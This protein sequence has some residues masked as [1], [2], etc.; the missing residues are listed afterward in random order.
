M[1]HTYK[2][3]RGAL[4]VDCVVFGVDELLNVGMVDAKDPHVGAAA[5]A[6]LFHHVGRGVEGPD[7]TDRAAGDAA[8]QSNPQNMLVFAHSPGILTRQRAGRRVRDFW[9]AYGRCC[10]PSPLTLIYPSIRRGPQIRA[11]NPATAR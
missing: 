1:A 3:P 8:G 10:H 6:A 4:T 5:G 2:Y 7:K 11:M 9:G